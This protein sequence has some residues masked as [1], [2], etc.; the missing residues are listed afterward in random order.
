MP[1]AFYPFQE[2]QSRLDTILPSAP[3]PNCHIS[4]TL[5]VLI[6]S[7]PPTEEEEPS[8]P[9]P[10]IPGTPDT[11]GDDVTKVADKDD[12]ASELAVTPTPIR[13][14]A[15]LK[16]KRVE[17]PSTSNHTE[18]KAIDRYDTVI[19]CSHYMKCHVGYTHLVGEEE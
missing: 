3:P 11:T 5:A 19:T 14:K 9:S 1:V 8:D 2:N 12:E 10:E 4:S 15:S 6:L 13:T 18:D 7:T 16:R 17:Q